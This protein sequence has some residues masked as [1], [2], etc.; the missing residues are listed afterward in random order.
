MLDF[1]S[2]LKQKRLSKKPKVSMRE[3]ARRTNVDPSY[4]SR[5]EKNEHT[6]S[7]QVVINIA[8]ALN[9]DVNEFL[10]K[11]GYTPNNENILLTDENKKKIEMADEIIE[12]LIKH[13]IIKQNEILTKEKRDW[14][15]KLL[16][17]AIDMSRM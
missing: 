14:L 15:L 3:L 12:H 16:D 11:A 6:P 4:I 10:I 7:R 8:K 9:E 5:I 1:G 13:G 2:Y 17:K